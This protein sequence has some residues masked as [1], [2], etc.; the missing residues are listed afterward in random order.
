MQHQLHT[1]NI[2]CNTC[3]LSNL[4][5]YINI[6]HMEVIAI[7]YSLLSLD[8]SALTLLV[9]QIPKLSNKS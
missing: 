3:D 1:I 4:Y 7:Q 6:K 2:E 8:A 5:T 9:K